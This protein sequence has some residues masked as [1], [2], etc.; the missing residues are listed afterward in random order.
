MLTKR[1]NDTSWPGPATAAGSESTR[2]PAGAPL[3]GGTLGGRGAPGTGR[4]R[5]GRGGGRRARRRRLLVHQ[6]DHGRD[7]PGDQDDQDHAADG[8]DDLL[9]LGLGLGIDFPSHQGVV[10]AGAALAAGDSG[11]VSGFGTGL[12]G[13]GGVAGATGVTGAV[14]AVEP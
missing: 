11:G 6:R 4:H 5:S 8:G 7:A 14:V 2:T 3:V 1:P 10:P 12:G 9:A 13:A